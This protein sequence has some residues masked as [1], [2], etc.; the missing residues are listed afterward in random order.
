MEVKKCTPTKSSTRLLT[1]NGKRSPEKGQTGVE[2]VVNLGVYEGST[3]TTTKTAEAHTGGCCS[4]THTDT[5]AQKNKISATADEQGRAST[6]EQ[7][8]TNAIMGRLE[9]VSDRTLI[10][11]GINNH[12]DK[13]KCEQ[14]GTF[15]SLVKNGNI[16]TGGKKCTTCNR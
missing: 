5:G 16:R 8:E 4:S 15:G 9:N 13:L 2:A 1:S 3:D 6:T 14:C 11:M 7:M 10:K 12:S